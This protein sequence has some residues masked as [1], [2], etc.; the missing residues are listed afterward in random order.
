MLTKINSSHAPEQVIN[1]I[2]TLFH[3]GRI[4][5]ILAKAPKILEKY[6]DTPSL[7]NIL[8]VIHFHQGFKQEA[9]NYFYKTIYIKHDD[10]R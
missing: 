6:P 3:Q 9:T 4:T 7:Y 8:G 10:S 1:A 5:D 2:T